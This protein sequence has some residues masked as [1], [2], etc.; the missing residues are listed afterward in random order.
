ME[1]EFLGTSSGTPTRTRNVSALALKS[2]AG[3]DWYLIDCGEGTQH[4]LLRSKLSLHH[5]QGVFIS[6]VHGDHCYGLPGLLASCALSGREEPLRIYGPPQIDLLL[7]SVGEL[8]Q[9]HLPFEV[10]FFDSAS[11]QYEQAE[12]GFSV[13][14]IALSHRVPSRGFVFVKQDRETKL[15]QEKLESMG[16]PRGPIW[17]SLQKGLTV[18]W[19]GQAMIPEEFLLHTEYRRKLIACGDNAHPECL[20]KEIA[21]TQ[22]LIHEATYTQDILDKVG[23]GP[24]HSSA[25]GIASYAEQQKIPNLI[26]THFSPRYQNDCRR[27]PSILD[28]ETEARHYYSGSLHLASDFARYTLD[29]NGQLHAETSATNQAFS[30]DSLC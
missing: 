17:G 19:Q 26:L 8:T 11:M 3:R 10:E 13:H 20:D 22:V 7:R 16:V 2:G 30:G 6:H 15:D 24:M 27:S 4:R 28:I 25:R 18:E 5:L 29:G 12:H 1:L 9:L 14:S 21:D 23:S